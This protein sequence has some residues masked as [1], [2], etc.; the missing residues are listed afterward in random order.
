VSNGEIASITTFF[1]GQVLDA[2][3]PAAR[4]TEGVIISRIRKLLCDGGSSCLTYSICIE[5][6]HPQN[7]SLL[8][9]M[10]TLTSVFS[11]SDRRERILY[12]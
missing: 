5:A 7:V 3:T 4:G 9:P 10:L 11:V 1:M 6:A 2:S 8:T 12:T